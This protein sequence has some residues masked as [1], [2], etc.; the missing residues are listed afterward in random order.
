[1]TSSDTKSN[2]KKSLA[3]A[4][5]IY[6]EFRNTLGPG[7]MNK[8][9]RLLLLGYKY[10]FLQFFRFS[11]ISWTTTCHGFWGEKFYIK[12][13][14]VP[15]LYLF[16]FLGKEEIPFTSFLINKDLEG[17]VFYD[18]G[19]NYGFYSLLFSFLSPQS[20]VYSLEP[21]PQI[22]SYLRKNTKSNEHI[23]ALDYAVSNDKGKIHFYNESTNRRGSSRSTT[24]A[25]ESL[26]SAKKITISSTTIDSLSRNHEPPT[27]IKLDIEGAEANALEG[28]RETLN[29]YKP[30]IVMEVWHGERGAKYSKQAVD[31]LFSHGYTAHRIHEDGSYE[32]L[33][34]KQVYKMYEKDQSDWENMLF[35]I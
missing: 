14:T 25:E 19:A 18:I 10:I 27:I 16:G 23:A 26:G 33:S 17:E 6:D 11:P 13:G 21:S 24:I 1:M 20:S 3:S 31:I 2:L 4:V 5:A 9:R 15:T 32:P 30:K 35:L 34:K 8:S 22:Y 28:A 29:K 12:S 7:V